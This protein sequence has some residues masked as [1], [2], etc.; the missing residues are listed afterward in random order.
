MRLIWVPDPLSRR[1]RRIR[2]RAGTRA[3]RTQHAMSFDPQTGLIYAR[4][5]AMLSWRRR[6]DDPFWFTAFMGFVPNVKSYGI[7]AAYDARTSK[8]VWKQMSTPETL[9]ASGFMSSAGSLLFRL[10]GDGNFTAYNAKTGNTVWQ[11]QTGHRGGSGQSAAYEINDSVT[12]PSPPVQWCGGSSSMAPF[13]QLRQA[14][15]S[16]RAAVLERSSRPRGSRPPWPPR[17]WECSVA[18]VPSR[19][20]LVQSIR[21]SVKARAMITFADTSLQT[22]TVVAAD[23]SWTTGPIAVTKD[24]GVRFDKPGPICPTSRSSLGS[25]ERSG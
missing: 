9:G 25:T 6:T 15:R 17:I 14:R 23:G 18:C 16:A 8:V 3:P 7:L 19:P 11:F 5:T 13:L 24:A 20:L 2:Q 21:A 4:G 1:R 12:S 10:A 22:T